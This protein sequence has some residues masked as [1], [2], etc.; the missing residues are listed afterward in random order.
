MPPILEL[1]APLPSGSRK[2]RAKSVATDD[3]STGRKEREPKADATPTPEVAP[4]APEPGGW[5]AFHPRPDLRIVLLIFVAMSGMAVLAWRLW[6]VQ[7]VDG[8]K[9]TARLAARSDVRVRIP[10]A[11][12]EIR[13]R[14]GILLAGNRA[15]RDIEFY[16][17]EVVRAF[18]ESHPGPVPTVRYPARI[19]GMLKML[20]EPDIVAIVNASIVPHLRELGLPTAFDPYDLARHFRVDAEVPFLFLEDADFATIAKFSEHA[21]GLPGVRIAANPI[22]EYPYGA[23]A[24]HLLGYVGEPD[25]IAKLPDVGKFDFYDPNVEGKA[26]VELLMDAALRGTPGVRVMQ[27]NVKG[28]IDRELRVEPPKPG[29][30]VLL[31]ID[32]RIQFITEQALRA[33]GRAGAVVVDPRNGDILAMASVPSFN[34]NAF[35]PSIS[36]EDWKKLTEDETDPLVNRA[37]CAYPPGSTFKAVTALAGLRK[38]LVKK[39]FSCT[40]GVTYGDHYFQCWKSSGHGSLTLSDAIK[41]S[42]NSFFYQYGNAAGIETMDTV[43]ALLGLGQP[44]GSGL[45]GEQPG[46]MPGPEWLRENY[47]LERW[48]SAYTAN[49]SIGQGYDLVS[50]LQLCMA[51]AAVANGGVTY[52]PRLIKCVADNGEEAPQVRGD[53]RNGRI[54]PEDFQ[55]LRDGFWKVVNE[56]GGTA[57]RA[58]LPGGIVAGKTGTAQAQRGGQEDTIA[59]FVCFAPF[60]APRYA[61]CVMVQGGAHGGSV[62]APIAAKILEDTF[63][64]ERGEQAP[65]LVRLEPARH[66]APFRMIESLDLAVAPVP[67]AEASTPREPTAPRSKRTAKS[68]R[69]PKHIPQV[70]AEKPREKRNFFER[71]FNFRRRE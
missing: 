20:S 33:V 35:I 57:R 49:V 15:Q 44:P 8:A 50:P 28:V 52:Y 32:A 11:R 61:V 3:G 5:E 36:G 16:L 2:R 55:L 40:G 30:N 17:P 56:D 34:P 66:P 54:K 25:D 1:R 46:V 71:L 67:A 45:S 23:L 37:I 18:R 68:P 58:R 48:T 60:D 19:H 65:T 39:S 14:H 4:K 64:M 53:L 27:R 38:G 62:A 41:V 9:Y 6:Q 22:R 12:G 63:A 70:S 42:C 47:P 29:D 10:P 26:Q 51:Y 21:F 7:V 43:G 69:A 59:W 13:D 31:T 24:A